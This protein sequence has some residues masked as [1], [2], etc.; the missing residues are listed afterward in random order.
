MTIFIVFNDLVSEQY[1]P[2]FVSTVHSPNF[3]DKI[4]KVVGSSFWMFSPNCLTKIA[5]KLFW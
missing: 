4:S 2:V 5:K 3:F 1:S